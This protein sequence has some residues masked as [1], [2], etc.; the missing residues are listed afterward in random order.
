MNNLSNL[1]IHIYGNFFV[2]CFGIINIDS[3]KQWDD[4]ID[5][6]VLVC[7]H[8]EP[9]FLC[10]YLNPSNKQSDCARIIRKQDWYVFDERDL[11]SPEYT[12]IRLYDF[13]LISFN[14]DA[15]S[16]IKF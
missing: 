10:A 14:V 12:T 16:Y 13:F 1:F 5:L 3:H 11:Q 8:V 9:S 4:G 7:A 6:N 15:V 2:W